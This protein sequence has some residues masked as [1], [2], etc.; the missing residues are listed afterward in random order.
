[1]RLR[2]ARTMPIPRPTTDQ[3]LIL[4]DTTRNSLMYNH[5][6]QRTLTVFS[7]TRRNPGLPVVSMVDSDDIDKVFFQELSPSTEGWRSLRV[8]VGREQDQ[9]CHQWFVVGRLYNR[10]SHHHTIRNNLFTSPWP[11]I[12]RNQVIEYIGFS[13]SHGAVDRGNK[14]YE[15]G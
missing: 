12:N 2:K 8:L 10:L 11:R 6:L 1:M 9:P 4:D 3:D 7:I 14:V 13:Q 5:S 15:E